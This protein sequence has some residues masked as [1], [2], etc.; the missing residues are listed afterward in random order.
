[1]QTFGN[2]SDPETWEFC[3]RRITNTCRN[4]RHSHLQTNNIQWISN[5]QILAQLIKSFFRC[6]AK[7]HISCQV[8]LSTP[9][10]IIVS[11]LDVGTDG[12]AGKNEKALRNLA[13][14]NFGHTMPL[15]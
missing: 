7:F 9:Q 3:P 8:I 2:S 6:Q 15:R 5:I 12:H 14:W 1:M 11:S 13:D 4:D 10:S